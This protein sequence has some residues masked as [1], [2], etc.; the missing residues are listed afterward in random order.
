MILRRKPVEGYDISF[1]IT[2][3]HL[4]DTILWRWGVHGKN[5]S[6]FRCLK[7]WYG[8]PGIGKPSET[9]YHDV[10]PGQDV[11]FTLIFKS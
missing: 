1:L 7:F 11:G 9:R 5:D 4:E 10:I 2:N 3:T 8:V 6:Q